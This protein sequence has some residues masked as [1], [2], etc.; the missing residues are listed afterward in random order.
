MRDNRRVVIT[1]LGTVTPIGHSTKDFWD[2]LISAKNGIRRISRFD[3]S[4]L[5]V[6]IAGEIVDFDPTD[7][8]SR[9][10]VKRLDRYGVYAL[11]SAIEAIE[12]SGFLDSNYDPNR[13]GVLISSGIG[14]ME[15]LLEENDKLINRGPERVSPFFIPKMIP[16]IAAGVVAI[17]YGFKGINFCI[18]SAC[19]SSA[20]SIGEAYWAI[21]RGDAD[22]V[23]AGGAEAPLIPL[24]IAG[25]ASMKALS[26]RNDEPE[27]ASRPFDARRDGFVIGEGAGTVILEELSHAERRGA[28]VYAE[29]VG[30]GATADAYHITAPCSD[31]DGAYRAM[32]IALESAGVSPEEIGY[33]NAHGTST[34]LN[35]KMETLAIKRLLGE[36]AYRIPVSSTKSMI[37]HLLG[38]SGA[39]EFIATVLS[40]YYQK[41]HPTRNYEFPDPECDLDYVPGKAR[42]V[43][44][45]Y[46]LTNSFGFG[47]HNASLLVSKYP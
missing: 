29:L 12:D 3:A 8:I 31:G 42:D 13:V 27:K 11:Y 6:Q 19:A 16:D 37:G 18:V 1:G 7:R 17:K 14:G 36:H 40:V 46:A 45:R 10:E 30:Y 20:H 28:R 39:V 38:G 4:N 24:A 35:D 47:G 34:E 43:E 21:K 44:I 32:K 33:V 5:P 2:S 25:F 9:K 15:T 26:T 23:V 41:V 22:I